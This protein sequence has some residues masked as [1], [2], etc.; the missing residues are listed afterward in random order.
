MLHVVIASHTVK[1]WPETSHSG[2]GRRTIPQILE[3]RCWSRYAKHNVGLINYPERICEREDE[4]R[5]LEAAF[6][7]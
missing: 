3:K 7:D 5:R 6:G 4:D 2:E 1:H